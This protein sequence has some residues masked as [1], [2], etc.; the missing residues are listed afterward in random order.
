MVTVMFYA[1]LH[2]VET[3]FAHERVPPPT[4]HTRRNQTLKRLSSYKPVWTHYRPL[5]DAART[6]RYEPAPIQWIPVEQVK[7]R[8]A[9]HF[10]ELE[11]IVQHMIGVSG[12]LPPVWPPA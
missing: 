1:A 6:A 9:G 3:L 12:P 5:Q 11:R 2:A 10:Y 7:T 4:G 8:L